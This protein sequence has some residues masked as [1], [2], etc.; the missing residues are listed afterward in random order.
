MKKILLI[1]PLSTLDFGSRTT[2]GVDS[3]CQIIIKDL[4]ETEY[5]GYYIRIL[6]FDPKSEAIKNTSIIKLSR[7]VDIIRFPGNEKINNIALP[8]LVSNFIRIKQVIAKYEPD[9]VHSHLAPWL[10][11]IRSTKRIATLHAYKKIARKPVSFLNDLLYAKILPWLCDF[12]VDKYTCVGTILESALKNDVKKPIAIIGNPLNP[13]YFNSYHQNN[14]S[15]SVKFITCALLTRR[16]RIDAV[17]KLVSRL[18]QTGMNVELTVVGPNVDK[19][20]WQ[21]LHHLVEQENAHKY[22]VFTGSKNTSEIKD[23]Y[24]QS[25]IGIFLSSEETF[26]LAPLEMLASGLPLISS[27]VG[28]I[29]EDPEFFERVGTCIVDPMQEDDTLLKAIAFI[30][31][32]PHVDL[33]ELKNKYSGNAVNK[34]YF[35][36][37][38]TLLNA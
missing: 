20:Y 36:I 16:K 33:E 35:L 2:G 14:D 5:K 6:A 24:A 10:L 11:G 9:I 15:E 38:K 37:Y 34:Q 25:D 12:Y 8:S 23:L 31:K 26:G 28:V 3:V 1:V 17:I 18:H 30:N 22:I 21:E 4:I 7:T 13:R 29:D 32:T 19:Q 27:K